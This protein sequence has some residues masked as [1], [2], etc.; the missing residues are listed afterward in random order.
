MVSCLLSC[1]D[2][3]RIFLSKRSRELDAIKE[4][5]RNFE[6]TINDDS[7]RERYNAK[8]GSHDDLICALGIA[9]LVMFPINSANTV[10]HNICTV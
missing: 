9:V 1:F 6:M 3:D 10:R 8:I 4:E 2:S 7:G 5:L